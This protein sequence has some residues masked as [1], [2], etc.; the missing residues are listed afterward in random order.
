[1]SVLYCM[2][3][4]ES[5]EPIQALA[6]AIILQAV[7]DYCSLPKEIEAT[8]SHFEKQRLKREI[9]LIRRF[10][11]SDWFAVLSDCDTGTGAL[12]LKALDKE[13]L[14]HHRGTKI[15]PVYQMGR[16]P[17]PNENGEAARS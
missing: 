6:I 9:G 14:S 8:G 3:H 10:F 7:S 15:S 12:I 13:V 1:M 11:L 4:L 16:K 17:A 5:C 2:E